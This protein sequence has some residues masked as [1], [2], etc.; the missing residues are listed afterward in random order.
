[1]PYA[2]V[3]IN[4]DML[5]VFRV[6]EGNLGRRKPVLTILFSGTICQRAYHMYSRCLKL[7]NE[8]ESE[9]R[10]QLN[11]KQ[12]FSREERWKGGKVKG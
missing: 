2:Y 12:A 6:V 7:D 10:R 4:S 11:G 9:W 3:T 1:M 8:Q 5:G